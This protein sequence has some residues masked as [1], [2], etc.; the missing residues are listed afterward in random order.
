MTKQLFCFL[1]WGTTL[2]IAGVVGAGFPA[3]A[4]LTV[5]PEA[6][7]IAGDRSR[8]LSTTLT[9][10]ND[11]GNTVLKSA[12]SDLRRADGAAILPASIIVI[13]PTE[14]T[15][16]QNAPAQ[17]T[18]TID[19]AQASANGEF[20]GLLY[21]YRSDGRQVIPLT[22]RV[23][24]APFWPW[25]VMLLG[26]GLGSLLSI[27][28][29]D[30][31]SRDEVVIQVSRLQNEMNSD[32]DLH[33]DFRAS[34][35]SKLV[36]VSSAIAD[37]DWEAAKTEVAAAK[38]LWRRWQEFRD[39]WIVQLRYGDQLIE[40]NKDLQAE[41][42][43][44]FIQGV[45]DNLDTVYRRLRAG[46]IETPQA[47][48]EVFS[49]IRDQLL[50]YQEGFAAVDR[51]KGRRL[52]LPKDKQD[53]WLRKL[54][55]LEVELRNS[56]P[57]KDSRNNWQ[58]SFKQKQDDLEEEIRKSPENQASPESDLIIL[59]RSGVNLPEDQQIPLV[60]SLGQNGKNHGEQDAKHPSVKQAQY[61]LWWF[62]QTSRCIAIIFLAWLGMIELYSGKST[63]GAEPL[64]DYFALLAWGFGA[65]LT[66]ESI[67]RVSQNLGVPIGG[68]QK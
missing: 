46:Q 62:N 26:V 5:S 56:K 34:I 22:V 31:R 66:R 58:G 57:D 39:D 45:K 60:P 7:V 63:F 16:P 1:R 30:G 18:L 33:K 27:Y 49:E 38:G 2:A 50:F 54:D 36:R 67:T 9:F 12:V 20:A 13:N 21:L 14:I 40:G 4:E 59:G 32:T 43:T 6:V 65:E 10:S 61:N 11:Q 55:V 41:S 17:T 24:E 42:P 44:I 23:K 51:L 64:R 8:T 68:E 28:R 52:E 48:S 15:V 3:F 29:V 37:K 25:M 53:E 35:E 19:L 47:L